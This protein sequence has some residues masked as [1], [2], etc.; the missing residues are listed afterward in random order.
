MSPVLFTL[1]LSQALKSPRNEDHKY[2]EPPE[3]TELA[4]P[5]HLK[6]YTYAIPRNTSFNIDQ[7]YAADISYISNPKHI[8]EQGKETIS[9]LLKKRNLNVNIS[10]TEEYQII[11][12]GNEDWK[13]CKYL[14]GLLDTKSDISR[15]KGLAINTYNKF[16]HILDTMKLTLDIK[17]RVLDTYILSFFLYNCE[18]WTLTN[19]LEQEI[20]LFQ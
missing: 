17:L 10:K 6:D 4:V 1:Y 13:K 9:P 16:Q 5:P 15:R 3:D 14:G 12:E 19:A 2:A 7:H 18:L 11:R 8:I 20:D